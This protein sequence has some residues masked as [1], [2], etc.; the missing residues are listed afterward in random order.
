MAVRRALG[1]PTEAA[2]IVLS[3][4]AGYI[5]YDVKKKYTLLTEFSFSSEL[6]RMSSI[7]ELKET[8]KDIFVFSKGAPENIITICSQIE[9]NGGLNENKRTLFGCD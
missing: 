1:S 5:P 9:I 3:E 4:K 2:L 6:K 8:N 7:Y